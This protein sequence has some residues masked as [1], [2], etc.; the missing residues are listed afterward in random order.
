MVYYY[1]SNNNKSVS[2]RSTSACLCN[3]RQLLT[4][5]LAIFIYNTYLTLNMG[6]QGRRIFIVQDRKAK[7]EGQYATESYAIKKEKLIVVSQFRVE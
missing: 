3:E 6:K 1:I 2:G 7:N 4:R 5:K